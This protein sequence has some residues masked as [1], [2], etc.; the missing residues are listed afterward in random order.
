[1]QD[2]EILRK[3]SLESILYFVYYSPKTQKDAVEIIYQKPSQ[4]VAQ[5][6]VIKARKNLEKINALKQVNTGDLRK[7]K[8]ISS[9]EPLIEYL[10]FI[11]NE[12]SKRSRAP[13][14]LYKLSEYD[15]EFLEKFFNSE[16]FRNTFFN[17][18]T[19]SLIA[20]VLWLHVGRMKNKLFVKSAFFTM[21]QI[22]IEILAITQAFYLKRQKYFP[23]SRDIIG[24]VSFDDFMQY[25]YRKKL[26]NINTAKINEVIEDLSSM[27]SFDPFTVLLTKEALKPPFPA[28]CLPPRFWDLFSHLE[29]FHRPSY[30][31]SVKQDVEEIL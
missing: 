7:I 4:E 10:K 16:W 26:N 8:L 6:P 2:S 27:Y 22:F 20:S 11:I 9:S 29:P 18:D 23:Q 13:P 30:Y 28:F 1:M 21:G 17:K 3:E 25:W 14:A 24:N 31:I 15:I 19:L 12:Q 5:N